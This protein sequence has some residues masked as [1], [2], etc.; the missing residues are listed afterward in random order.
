MLIV[1]FYLRMQISVL[2][3]ASDVTYPKLCPFGQLVSVSADVKS[4]LNAFVD[5]IT[6]N[7]LY[8]FCFVI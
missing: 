2:A 7:G 6:K 3:L 5:D 1:V 8:Y 4:L